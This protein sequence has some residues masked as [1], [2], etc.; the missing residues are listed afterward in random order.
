MQSVTVQ[1]LSSSTF[2]PP[3]LDGSLLLPDVFDHHAQHSPDHPL[4]VYAEDKVPKTITWSHA[5]KAFRKAAHICQV[6]VEAAEREP[7]P[8]VVAILALADQITYLSI[9]IGVMLAG[10]LPFPLSPRNSE[11]AIVHLFRSSSCT[12]VFVS[13]DPSMQNLAGAARIGI[14][15]LEENLK[16]MPIPTFQELFEPSIASQSLP[17]KKVNLDDP[18][19]LMHSSGSTAF[20][21]ESGL[22]PYYGAVDLCGEVLSVHA[23]P[24]FHMLGLVQLPYAAFTGMAMS[25]FFPTAPP[26][27]PTPDRVFEV[28]I[29]T[30]STLLIC[31]PTFLESWA[32]DPA[33]ISAMK[34]FITVIFGEGRCSPTPGMSL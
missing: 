1:G 7:S 10:Y 12:R 15:A 27:A 22:I 4:F 9:V 8:T 25:G 34:K 17:R 2:K 26:V 32:S 16:I 31:A 24:M 14:S 3:P 30:N 28:A 29:A 18:A 6:R 33:Q 11:A 5:V 13:A 21:K 19:V 23:V 20:P